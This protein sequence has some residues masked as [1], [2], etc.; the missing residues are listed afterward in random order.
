M[1]GFAVP[2]AGPLQTP[3]NPA[4]QPQQTAASGL[5][6]EDF[7]RQY[8][9]THQASTNSPAEII[10]AL[11][12]AGYNA[13]P[14]MYGST[15]SG[16]EINLNGQK[17][18]VIGGENSGSPSWYAADTDD[19]GGGGA[20]PG[21]LGSLAGPI[22][23][24][25]YGVPNGGPLNQF[26]PL[27]TGLDYTNDPGVQARLKMGTDAIQNSAAAKGTLLSGKSLADLN[28]YAQDYASNEYGNAFNRALQSQDAVFG[29]NLNL[30]QLGLAGAGQLSSAYG[31]NATNS[32]N[33]ITNQ[34][35]A[36]AAANIAQGNN[37]ASTIANL[38]NLGLQAYYQHQLNKP[39]VPQP[40][41]TL[42]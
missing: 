17:Y 12:H 35:N 9:A 33:L 36:N 31:S 37:D 32:G 23:G 2:S 6:A 41:V 20:A 19:S 38:G 21:S 16:N 25:L 5:S 29:R 42:Q 11:Q 26:L 10:A 4:T 18:K 27:P 15:T 1:A 13:S 24:G 8:Q 28:S 30:A 3:A 22:G 40:G 14:Y 7:I 34:G 39:P